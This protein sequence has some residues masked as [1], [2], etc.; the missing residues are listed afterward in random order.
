M[1]HAIITL[2]SFTS[3]RQA[4]IIFA[5]VKEIESEEELDEI[6]KADSRPLVLLAGFTWCRPCKVLVAVRRTKSP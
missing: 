3:C 6:I 2:V 5:Q 1:L 4:R